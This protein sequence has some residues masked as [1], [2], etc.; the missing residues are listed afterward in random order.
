MPVN[1]IPGGP[2]AFNGANGGK[3]YAFTLTTSP[4]TVAPANP[5]RQSITFHNPGAQD[6]FVCPALAYASISATSPTA[7]TP[8]TG[9]TQGCFRVFSNGGT[10]QITG[11]CQG[12][13]QALCAS[14]TIAFTVMDSNIG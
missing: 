13:W 7:L 8:T 14:S 2:G 11:E 9:A 1:R 12:A 3:I 5:Q 4:Q 10:L 6:A